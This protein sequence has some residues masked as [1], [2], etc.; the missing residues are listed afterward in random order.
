M[1]TLIFERELR[2]AMFEIEFEGIKI[3]PIFE[4]DEKGIKVKESQYI[5]IPDVAA[6]RR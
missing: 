5:S 2:K 1:F 6:F 3:M 4:G